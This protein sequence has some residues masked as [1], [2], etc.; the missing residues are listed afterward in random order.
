MNILILNWRDPKNPQA[1]GAEQL[2]HEMAKRWV[3]AG[4]KVMQISAMFK[5]A[6]K[7]ESID[8]VHVIRGGT[9]W[10]VHL[11]AC[12][13]YLRYLRDQTD[14]VI[15]E[16]HWFPFYSYLYAPK[17]TVAFVCE[18]A[19]RLF[20]TV[21]PYPVALCWRLIE[22]VYLAVYKNI[23]TMVISQST[24][25]DLVKEGHEIA[26]IIV[27]PMGLTVPEELK[28]YP[29]EKVSTLI[30]VARLNK[31]K[32]IYDV[33][34][35]FAL[36]CKELPDTKLWIIGSGA[37]ATVAMVKKE[38]ESLHLSRKVQL[39]GFVSEEQKFELLAR[40]HLLISASVQEGWGLTVPEAGLTKTPAV[41][42]NIQGFKDIIENKKDGILVDRNPNA[43]AEGVINVL[44][45]HSM[46]KKLQTAAEKKAKEYTWEKTAKVA[47][48]FLKHYA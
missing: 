3:T 40:A 6:K 20:Y 23:P 36:V 48:N 42:Y 29:K 31:Q 4:N 8:G 21:F 12:Y 27:L 17:K 1:G 47:L 43:L 24:R 41:V 16:V 33:I 35:A 14:I 46:Y 2:T 18:V 32:G 37:E 34:N 19:N 13:Y 15:D 39:F 7:Q 30:Y 25:E 9:W 28:Q 44:K 10:N 5:N 26:N 22:K 11:F 45:D 38:I